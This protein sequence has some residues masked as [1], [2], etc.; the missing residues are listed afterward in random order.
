MLTNEREWELKDP[1]SATDDLSTI[2]VAMGLGT[3]LFVEKE[4]MTPKERMGAPNESGLR[5]L[6]G[7][8]MV[9]KDL[10]ERDVERPVI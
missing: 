2:E 8:E 7:D 6:T 5:P 9:L 1:S 10:V 4:A 3:I